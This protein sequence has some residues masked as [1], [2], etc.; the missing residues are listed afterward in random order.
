M[1]ALA[2]D[3][4]WSGIRSGGGNWDPLQILLFGLQESERH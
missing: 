3:V 2:K 4:G 1:Q